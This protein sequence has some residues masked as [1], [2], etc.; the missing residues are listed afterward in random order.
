MAQPEHPAKVLSRA[1]DGLE[2]PYRRNAVLWLERCMQRPVG[3]LEEDLGAFL[4]ELHPVVRESFIQH[5]RHLLEDAL[6]YFGRD[7]RTRRAARGR[8]ST[9]RARL[10]AY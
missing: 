10:L 9:E 4:D 2:E 3:S 1:V 6:D 8:G 7:R 5:T